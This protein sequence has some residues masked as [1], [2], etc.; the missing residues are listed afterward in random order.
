M[1]IT[2]EP[3]VYIG[4]SVNFFG[5]DF[6][7]ACPDP[8]SSFLRVDHSGVEQQKVVLWV[9]PQPVKL[10]PVLKC[11]IE[12]FAPPHDETRIIDPG[13]TAIV[14]Q[15]GT[16]L[17]AGA[18]YVAMPAVIAVPP[19][20][21]L[22]GDQKNFFVVDKLDVGRIREKAADAYYANREQLREKYYRPVAGKSYPSKPLTEAD[23]AAMI[24]QGLLEHLGL[25]K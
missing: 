9:F 3:S 19:H 16:I 18:S 6:D 10:K 13:L 1:S 21:T 15:D 20:S 25:G 24:E 2:F 11:E 22:T 5:L 23:I 17:L 7:S 12:L 14:S 4:R 8:A